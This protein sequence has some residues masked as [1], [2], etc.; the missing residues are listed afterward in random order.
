MPN[1]MG[2]CRHGQML[3]N[4]ADLYVGKSLQLYGEFS[5]GETVLFEQLV[6]P[7][8][9]VVEVGA[10]YGAHTLR[11]AQLVGPAGRV[12]AFEPQRPVFQALCGTLALNSLTNVY[13]HNMA[14]GSQDSQIAVPVLDYDRPGNFGGLSLDGT[15]EGATE[16]VPLCR[17]DDLELQQ[18]R[19]LKVDVEGM[20][21]EVLAGALELVE[22]CQ[23]FLYVENDRPA[24]APALMELLRSLPYDLYWHNPPLY[25]PSNYR[26]YAPNVFPGVVSINVLG[27]PRGHQ[28]RLNGFQPVREDFLPG[29][30]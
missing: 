12:Y 25:N 19:L 23:P 21:R 6:R 5:Y 11:L 7:G 27:V 26:G 1:V 13:A 17:L 22:R 20:E 29:V 18:C 24:R 16:I 2:E 15:H 3:Y 30:Q 14:M 9:V 10:N 28:L 4:P 8:D